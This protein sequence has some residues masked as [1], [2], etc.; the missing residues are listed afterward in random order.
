MSYFICPDC[1][2]RDEIFGAGG[3]EKM[4]REEHLAL[5]AK[6]PIYEEVRAA[7]DSGAPITIADRE[8]PASGVFLQIAKEVTSRTSPQ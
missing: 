7:G 2:E 5:I 1:G 6:L 3:G 8:H 4:A